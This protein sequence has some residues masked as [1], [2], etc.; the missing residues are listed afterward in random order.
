MEATGYNEFLS[1]WGFDPEKERMDLGGGSYRYESGFPLAEDPLFDSAGITIWARVDA[2]GSSYRNKIVVKGPKMEKEITGMKT[3]IYADAGDRGVRKV[4][5]F[6]GLTPEHHFVA[7]KSFVDGLASCGIKSLLSGVYD[8]E[9]RYGRFHD[10]DFGWAAFL[11]WHLLSALEQVA[12]ETFRVFGK[13]FVIES[14]ERYKDGGQ[15]FNKLMWYFNPLASKLI[16]EDPGVIGALQ[17]RVSTKFMTEVCRAGIRGFH[18]LYKPRLVPPHIAK[19]LGAHGDWFER[20]LFKDGQEVRDR[21]LFEMVGLPSKR[22]EIAQH[23]NFTDDELRDISNERLTTTLVGLARRDHLPADIM[24]KLATELV[25]DE[26]GR[27]YSIIVKVALLRRLNLPPDILNL[28]LHDTN[29]RVRA[30]ITR[31]DGLEKKI[32][33]TLA[34]DPEWRVRVCLAFR[35]DV[36][37][38]ILSI[39]QADGDWRVRGAIY[40]GDSYY[41]DPWNSSKLRRKYPEEIIIWLTSEA[42][43]RL[44]RGQPLDRTSREEFYPFLATNRAWLVRNEVARFSVLPEPLLRMLAQDTDWRV[45]RNVAKRLKLPLDIIKMLATDVSPSVRKQFH[46][47]IRQRLNLPIYKHDKASSPYS[48]NGGAIQLLFQ[49]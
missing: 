20:A 18:D 44:M 8:S 29:E 16:V 19:V 7:L 24:R 11:H 41:G 13:Q 5:K 26:W 35:K 17:G 3:V 4:T 22:Q 1:I 38:D 25:L 36:P 14:L 46:T 12:P 48:L 32:L 47:K 23:E 28:M 30:E 31:L 40:L 6:P 10:E 45:R 2:D 43:L 49:E 15:S 33:E 42:L 27:D 9:D 39:L 34:R 21:D 37:K